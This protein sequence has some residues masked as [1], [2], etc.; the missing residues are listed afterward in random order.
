MITLAIRYMVDHNKLA[1]FETYVRALPAHIERCGGKCVGYYLPTKLAG[2]SN[3]ALGLI[4][5]PNLSAYEQ[6]REKLAADSR[7][8]DTLRRA[9]AAGCILSEDRSFIRRVPD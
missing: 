7:A 3:A 2:P 6:Y 4:D 8:V 9:E 1:D 5:F